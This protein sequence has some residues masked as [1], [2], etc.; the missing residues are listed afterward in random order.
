ML[1]INSLGVNNNV[2]ESKIIYTYIYEG[3][4]KQLL[5]NDVNIV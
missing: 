4:F 2:D 5:I 3:W 1:L